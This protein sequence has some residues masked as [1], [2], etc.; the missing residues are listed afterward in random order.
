MTSV[1]PWI[2]HQQLPGLPLIPVPASP[3][4]AIL[5]VRCLPGQCPGPPSSTR[6]SGG[7][8]HTL[9]AAPICWLPRCPISGGD[10]ASHVQSHH[11]SWPLVLLSSLQTCFPH[12]PHLGHLAPSSSQVPS[13][14]ELDP[15][16]SPSPTSPHWSPGKRC[17]SPSVS[18]TSP[19]VP[20][21]TL[22]QAPVFSQTSQQPP[23]LYSP[24][25]NPGFTLLPDS[26]I[27]HNFVPCLKTFSD[28]FFFGG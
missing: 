7:F 16:M 14:Q 21:S 10:V 3:R 5:H 27:L 6:R 20:A 23:C 24:S 18:F 19:P 22:A 1:A 17:H 11:S 2:P 4:L 8:Q 25:P 15:C 26:T 13:A 28:S 9:A 12:S